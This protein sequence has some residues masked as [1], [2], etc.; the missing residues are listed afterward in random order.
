MRL[1]EGRGVLAAV[2]SDWICAADRFRAVLR[3]R[4]DRTAAARHLDLVAAEAGAPK[5]P[6][7]DDPP[8]RANGAA[9]AVALPPVVGPV[10]P[11]ASRGRVA[12]VSFL[13]NWPSTG[14]GIIHTVELARFLEKAGYEVVHVYAAKPDWGVG[15]VEA[16]V[17]FDSR[18][19]EFADRD[20]NRETILRRYRSAV[21]AVRPDAVI[22]TDAWNMKPRLAAAMA[23][24]PVL[25]RQ[26]GLECVC[27]LNNVRLLPRP[28]GGFAQCDFDQLADPDECRR[29]LAARGG[30]SGGLPWVLDERSRGVRTPG[31]FLPEHPALF[32]LA[33]VSW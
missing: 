18:A 27:P 1:M 6:A 12:V 13:F 9:T 29:C 22:V 30:W 16:A 26:Q 17:P 8:A 10:A 23:G 19:L 21:D 20:W 28:G 25:P 14:G 7:V 5:P 31:S 24:L 4:P 32:P 33:V 3:I 15:R 11:A 2:R